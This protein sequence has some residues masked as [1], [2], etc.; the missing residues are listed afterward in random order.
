[1]IVY[2]PNLIGIV[3]LMSHAK[4]NCC[5]MGD[6]M[7]LAAAA[8]ALVKAAAAAD[9]AAACWEGEF[10]CWAAAA[11]AA[12]AWWWGD[13]AP[14]PRVLYLH[15]SSGLKGSGS[16]SR[17]IPTRLKGGTFIMTRFVVYRVSR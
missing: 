8:A 3:V 9:T 13:P 7:L 11:A 2:R 17:S 16:G 1:M 10:D 14:G 15:K 6:D 4:G 12:A 5:W